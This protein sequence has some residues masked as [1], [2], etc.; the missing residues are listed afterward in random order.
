[1]QS[2]IKSL[3][4][5]WSFYIHQSMQC[6]SFDVILDWRRRSLFFLFLLFLVAEG[7]NINR[8]N[9][10]TMSS[11]ENHKIMI[12]GS[13]SIQ[14][15]AEELAEHYMRKHPE[16]K[17]EVQGG[18]SS[19]GIQAAKSGAANIGMSSR[20]LKES[21]K[22]LIPTIIAYDAIVLVVHPTNPM[23]NITLQQIQGIFSYQIRDWSEIDPNITGEITMITREEGSGTRGAFE[24]LAMHQV[25]IAPRCLVQDSTGAV[26]EIVADDPHAIGYISVGALNG[27]VKPL[28]VEGIAVVSLPHYAQTLS[29]ELQR[30]QLVMEN[31]NTIDKSQRYRLIRPFLFV[32][33]KPLTGI[34][35]N[36]VEYI[37]SEEGKQLLQKEGLIPKHD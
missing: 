20:E 33:Q 30:Y 27:R 19:A 4:Q 6:L 34:A 31:I 17:I 8:H 16:N 7:C 15:I 22:D 3:W 21:E 32:S 28:K 18:G 23:T 14:P 24:E 2:D 25:E 10:S 35:K 11:S 12:A 37:Y 13:T 26:R 36:F 5:T 29:P 1:M 9:G